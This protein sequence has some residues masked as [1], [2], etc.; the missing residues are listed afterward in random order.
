MGMISTGPGLGLLVMSP[1]M[2]SLL[3][4]IGWRKSLMVTAVILCV[5]CALAC[6]TFDPNVADG[7]SVENVKENKVEE[8]CRSKFRGLLDLS[9]CRNSHFL[10]YTAATFVSCI[11]HVVPIVHMVSC[12]SFGLSL[13][14]F[15]WASFSLHIFLPSFLSSFLPPSLPSIHPSIPPSFLISAGFLFLFLSLLLF[16]LFISRHIA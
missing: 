16:V 1:I 3:D 5:P 13:P 7:L 10:I 6:Y 15:S 12:L 11:G 9:V 14:C 2:Q 8:T 4:V